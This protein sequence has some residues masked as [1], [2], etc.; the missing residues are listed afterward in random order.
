MSLRGYEVLEAIRHHNVVLS[1]PEADECIRKGYSP[2]SIP[3]KAGI[4]TLCHVS[5]PP[6]ISS[7]AIL[8]FRVFLNLDF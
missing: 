1:P 2:L 6:T 3:A 4:Y 8:I 5:N 7:F